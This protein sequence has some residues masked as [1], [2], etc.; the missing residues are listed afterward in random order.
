MAE[1]WFVGVGLGSERDLS[2]RA[3]DLLDRTE[4]ILAE[5][6]TS[7]LAPGSIDRLAAALGR[8]IRRL[9]REEL[10][11]ETPVLEALGRSARVALLVVGD[12]FAAT[13]HTAL[14]VA[15]ERAGHTWHY[16]PNASILTAA[17]SF[18]GLMHYRFG[19]TVS[20]PFPA[21]GFAPTSFLD[22]IRENRERGLH[23]LLLLD[24]RPSEPA[25]LT[26]PEA[27]GIL[28]DRDRSR[29]ALPPGAE[30][31][32][33]ARIGSDSPDAWYGSPEALARVDFGPPLHAL[34]VPGGPLH[35]VE[36]AAVARFRKG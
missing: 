25:Y 15:A 1:L 8:P 26:A 14:R 33:V 18:L 5:E 19:R 27:I 30:L 21:P 10:E 24:L 16:L 29:T 17:A 2:G 9:S 36:A 28:R 20:I 35:E 23:T 6:Y 31:A 7:L 13:T 11:S 32:V 12:P 34:V 3:R 4:S 22:G